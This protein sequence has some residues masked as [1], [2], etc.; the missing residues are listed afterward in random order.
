[1]D[2]LKRASHR[3]SPKIVALQI[4]KYAPRNHPKTKK[5]LKLLS[6]FGSQLPPDDPRG[7]RQLAPE[8]LAEAAAEEAAAEAALRRKMMEK[9]TEAAKY[10]QRPPPSRFGSQWLSEEPIPEYQ[11]KAPLEILRL[12]AAAKPAQGVDPRQNKE[13]IREMKVRIGQERDK[14]TPD[15]TAL[16]EYLDRLNMTERYKGREFIPGVKYHSV[17]T[18]DVSL[19]TF[20]QILSGL[21]P[22]QQQQFVPVA[23]GFPPAGSPFTVPQTS[24]L[25]V[26]QTSP[27]TV[28][29][30]PPLAGSPLLSMPAGGV[31]PAFAPIY[32]TKKRKRSPSRF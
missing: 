10:Q 22:Q 17:V 20:Q 14:N 3:S 6:S 12:A 9:L 26:P 31:A 4:K 7:A 5:Y 23:T 13:V 30:P 25:T 16:K 2:I 21:N 1:M 8:F 28:G 24:P 19:D 11:K 15:Y 27:S 32:R 29:S 18:G